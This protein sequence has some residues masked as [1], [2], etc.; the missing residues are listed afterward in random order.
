MPLACRAGF[1]RGNNQTVWILGTG[2]ANACPSGTTFDLP[3][4]PK[5]N[6][7]LK[8]LLEESSWHRALINLKAI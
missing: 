6:F 7:D 1:T 5:E 4:H 2:D 8:R 3:R